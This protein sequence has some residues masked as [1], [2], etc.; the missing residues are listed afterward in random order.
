VE[1]TSFLGGAVAFTTINAVYRAS[2]GGVTPILATTSQVPPA[3]NG[4]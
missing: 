2:A 3:M 1:I 4:L